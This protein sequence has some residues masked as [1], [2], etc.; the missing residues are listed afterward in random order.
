MADTVPL[1]MRQIEIAR[2][3]GPEVLID[4]RAP[5][6]TPGPGEVLIAVEAAGINRPDVLQRLGKHPPPPGV[7]DVPGL[8]VAGKVV[9]LGEQVHG[10][11]L[12]DDVCALLAGGG[13]T[14]Y[15]V[16]PATQCLPVPRGYSM[17]EAAA[18]PENYFTVWSNLF[19]RG[20][21]KA[22]ETLLVHGG[23]SGIGTTAIQ[24]ASYFGAKVIAT[25]G[26]ARKCDECV[27]LGADRAINYHREDFEQATLEWT[28]GR[29]VDMVLDIVGGP[30]TERNLRSLSVEG[31]LIQ[32]AFLEGSQITADFR[33]LM[34][35]RLTWTGS[36]LRPQSLE[37][38]SA[39]AR[40]LRHKIW[41]LLE[42]GYVRPLIYTTFPITQAAQAHALME[43][44][45]HIG[46]IVLS[47]DSKQ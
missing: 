16:A 23:T 27:R 40:D 28:A 6:P 7:T 32:I 38:K 15:C 2:H 17:V 31:R 36:T 35:R 24:L 42:A 10:V 5:V 9:A 37:A 33:T 22:G 26:S 45:A 20:N 43:S 3:G 25:A 14:E 21:L 29:G 8:E 18:L 4:R 30:Y 34:A 13:Y 47:A 12:G 11:A 44:G 39:I 41:P 1:D 46:K 19:Q